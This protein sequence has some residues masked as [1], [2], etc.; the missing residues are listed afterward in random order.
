[1]K[2]IHYTISSASAF[3]SEEEANSATSAEVQVTAKKTDDNKWAVD[4]VYKKPHY[5]FYLPKKVILF[6]GLNRPTVVFAD[7]E[8]SLRW[9]TEER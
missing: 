1:V 6:Q 5:V 4:G 3:T 8:E 9:Q 7:P 2:E